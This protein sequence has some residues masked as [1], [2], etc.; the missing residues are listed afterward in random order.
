MYSNIILV[1]FTH[2]MSKSVMSKLCQYCFNTGKVSPPLFL[3][4]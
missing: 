2:T 4:H 3:E 1:H